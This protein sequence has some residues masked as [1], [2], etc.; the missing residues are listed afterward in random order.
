MGNDFALFFVTANPHIQH[1]K[2]SP[3]LLWATPFFVVS[4][5]ASQ[6][7]FESGR[8][9]ITVIITII[10]IDRKENSIKSQYEQ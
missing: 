3:L 6:Q 1:K 7:A 10:I 9:I 5:Q 2:C 8:T 4:K